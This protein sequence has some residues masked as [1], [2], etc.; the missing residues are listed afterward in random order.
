[1]KDESDK[2]DA[3][4]I[5]PSAFRLHPYLLTINGG[6]S[7]IKFAVYQPDDSLR[8]LAGGTIERLDS[9]AGATEAVTPLIQYLNERFGASSVAAVGHRI[10][11]GGPNLL[12]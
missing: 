2:A 12:E 8:L 3:A 1:M 4:F 10:V 9:K 6:S 11:H 7:S 5:H